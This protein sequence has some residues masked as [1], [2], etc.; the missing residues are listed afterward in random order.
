MARPKKTEEERYLYRSIR[1]PPELWERL[2]RLVPARLR[3]G[4]IHRGLKRELDRLEREAKR[5]GVEAA[6]VARDLAHEEQV[7]R[8]IERLKARRDAPGRD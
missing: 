8:Q 2:G 1:W 5:R 4:V 6:E 7:A 3:S